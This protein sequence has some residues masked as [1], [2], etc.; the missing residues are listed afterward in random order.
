MTDL[1]A[2]HEC[3]M[4]FHRD[5]IPV[6]AKANCTRC[7]AELY[8]HIDNSLD[9]SLALYL[10][11]FVFMI[12]ANFYPFITMQTAGIKATSIVASGGLALYQFGMGELGFVVFLTSILLPFVCVVSMIY[13][14]VPARFG[15]LPPLYGPVYRIVRMCE[16]WSLLAV[17]MLGTLIA[18][19]KLQDLASV[20]PGL[21]MLGFVLMLVTYSAARSNFDPEVLWSRCKSDLLSH[22]RAASSPSPRST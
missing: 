6:G 11:T 21:G 14:L 19:V 22:L 8:R 20:I 16:P 3:D 15:K 13:L 7:G 17:F 12:I 9:R 18:A 1:V 2:C 4:L 10:S 5:E